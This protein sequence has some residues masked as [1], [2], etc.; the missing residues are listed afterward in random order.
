MVTTQWS[1]PVSGYSPFPP[2][3]R[4]QKKPDVNQT[5]VH[6][7]Q[8]RIRRS[9]MEGKLDQRIFFPVSFA[10]L[11]QSLHCHKFPAADRNF[12]LY[13]FA[14]S[15]ELADDLIF[16]I[17]DLQGP[18]FQQTP[19]LVRVMERPPLS[20]SFAPSSS[21]RAASCLESV[22]WVIF[23][24]SAAFVKLCSLANGQ[25]IAQYSQIH[26]RSPR[27][28]FFYHTLFPGKRTAIFSFSFSGVP[29]PEPG[30]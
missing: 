22:G 21:S 16:Q 15:L 5:F 1:L 3:S 6:P 18:S 20:K 11:R 27:L 17:D 12:A 14:V 13:G 28:L 24:C 29:E 23:S 8:D 19:S 30:R 2:C 26:I 4:V 9:R 10:D 7:V 25:K